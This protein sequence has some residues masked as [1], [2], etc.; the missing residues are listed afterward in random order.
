MIEV[1][2][3]LRQVFKASDLMSPYL[4]ASVAGYVAYHQEHASPKA[5]R[6]DRLMARTVLRPAMAARDEY[7]GYLYDKVAHWHGTGRYHYTQ[8]GVV[9]VLASV[10]RCGGL[11]PRHDLFDLNGPTNS[12]SLAHSRM[13]AR[14]Y[15]DMHGSGVREP[16]RYG[17]SVF[18]ACAYLGNVAVEAS[19]HMRVWRPSG[20]Y[21]MMDHLAR[22]NSMEWYR[23]VT[24]VDRPSI[25]DI[26]RRGSDIPGN[27]PVLFGVAP[28]ETIESSSAVAVHEARTDKPLGLEGDIVHVEVPRERIDETRHVLGRQVIITSLE[29]GER[30]SAN[31]TFSEHIKGLL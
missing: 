5:Q 4:L 19:K 29:D 13:Y 23:K 3:P 28:A 14:A 18:W 7:V 21:G 22:A 30:F 25:I 9:D 1:K 26:Y 31:Y 20:Y 2:H 8:D 17:N 27:Y 11:M 15:A 12:I 10:A 16:E 24:R 6:I